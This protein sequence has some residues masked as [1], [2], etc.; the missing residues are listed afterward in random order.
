MDGFSLMGFTKLVECQMKSKIPL[1]SV[2]DD[3]H[4]IQNDFNNMHFP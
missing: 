3:E 4:S 2:Y 1:E